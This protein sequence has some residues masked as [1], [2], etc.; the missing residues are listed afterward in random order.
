MSVPIVRNPVLNSNRYTQNKN[1]PYPDGVDPNN[2]PF[3]FKVIEIIGATVMAIASIG[4]LLLIVSL[5][6][7]TNDKK[8]KYKKY[9]PKF[10]HGFYR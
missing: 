5:L 6:I 9:F 3:I 8:Q 2:P 1:S 10:M 7:I 4:M